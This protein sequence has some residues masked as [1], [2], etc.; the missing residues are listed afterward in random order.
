M[1]EP[2]K[3]RAVELFS[4]FDSLVREAK[5][6]MST[7]AP[8]L[9]PLKGGP[10]AVPLL[11]G[12][13]IWSV[14]FEKNLIGKIAYDFSTQL[15]TH[16][17]RK[18]TETVVNQK[19]N[20]SLVHSLLGALCQLILGKNRYRL[21]NMPLREVENFLRQD[22]AIPLWKKEEFDT[23]EEVWQQIRQSLDI[24]WL[25]QMTIPSKVNRIRLTEEKW[26]SLGMIERLKWVESFLQERIRPIINLDGGDLAVYDVLPHQIV[27]NW[28]G[29]CAVCPYRLEGSRKLLEE[30]WRLEW[31][32]DR[33]I[34]IIAQ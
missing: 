17:F 15:P 7:Q 34:T 22:P 32:S 33:P 21:A 12:V 13:I 2:S 20:E 29:Q 18:G 1:V 19:V 24:F 4:T 9:L 31:E 6:A 26:L 30:E 16:W 14:N 8:L 27:L 25:H 11:N 28:K 3:F 10:G 23:L 5:E